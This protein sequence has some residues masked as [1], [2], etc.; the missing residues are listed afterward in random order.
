MGGVLDDDKMS[1]GTLLKKK[2]NSLDMTLDELAE[3]AGVS[4]SHLHG[5]EGDK[6]EPGILMCA[7]LSVALGLPVQAM[8]AAA[9]TGALQDR[10][11][12]QDA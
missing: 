10:G 3:A 5:L 4:K 9:L 11:V 7:K 12:P 1:L 2:R 8:A 6:S